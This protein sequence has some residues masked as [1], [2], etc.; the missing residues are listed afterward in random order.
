M[1]I[2]LAKKSLMSTWYEILQF[3]WFCH[4]GSGGNILKI[5]RTALM[6]VSFS[7]PCLLT[8]FSVVIWSLY[9]QGLLG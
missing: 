1:I 3:C 5:I 2:K 4:S 9:P 8:T 6:F 7:G